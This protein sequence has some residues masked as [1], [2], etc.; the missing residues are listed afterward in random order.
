M[1]VT[2][3]EVIGTLFDSVSIASPTLPISVVRPSSCRTIFGPGDRVRP[4]PRW[5]GRRTPVSQTSV[6]QFETPKRRL[7]QRTPLFPSFILQ[8][9]L[10]TDL[11]PTFLSDLWTDIST[12]YS[13]TPYFYLFFSS[14]SPARPFPGRLSTHYP[15]NQSTATRVCLDFPKHT[16]VSGE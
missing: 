15:T 7:F 5:C 6:V 16:Y 8:I 14:L 10:T 9:R 1:R 3:G 4:R 12:L 2:Q 13:L 11:S